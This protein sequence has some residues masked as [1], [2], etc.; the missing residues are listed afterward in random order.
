MDI[1]L[2]IVLMWISFCLMITGIAWADAY[3]LAH[4]KKDDS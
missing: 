2:A 3:R 4:K 1:I